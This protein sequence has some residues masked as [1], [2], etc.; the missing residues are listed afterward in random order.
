MYVGERVSEV[1]KEEKIGCM[2]VCMY[3]SERESERKA[4]GFL[5]A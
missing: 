2:Y 3:A 4:G 1:E 5:A